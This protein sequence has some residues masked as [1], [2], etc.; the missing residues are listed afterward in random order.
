MNGVFEQFA[1][2]VASFSEVFLFSEA[3]DPALSEKRTSNRE[4]FAFYSR[5]GDIPE[6]IFSGTVFELLSPSGGNFDL[7]ETGSNYERGAKFAL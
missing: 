1:V 5:N 4:V 6:K 7:A 3:P 2:D